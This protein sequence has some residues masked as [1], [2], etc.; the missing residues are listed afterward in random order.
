LPEAST[1]VQYLKN[2]VFD[3]KET[4]PTVEALGNK[5][6]KDWHWTEIKTILNISDF[7][8][9]EKQFSLGQLVDLNVAQHADEIVNISVTAT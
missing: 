3:F 8:L 7:P 6:L 4:M 9:Q 2:M 5:D 1:A